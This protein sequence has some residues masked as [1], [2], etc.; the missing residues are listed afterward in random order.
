MLPYPDPSAAS[1][2]SYACYDHRSRT[3][4]QFVPYHVF[5]YQLAGQTTVSDGEQTHQFAA[6]SFR[7]LRRNHL[8]KFTKQP[9]AGGNEFRTVAR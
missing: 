2:I 3:G 4:E 1:R 6:G 9:P 7:L 8:F 5:S